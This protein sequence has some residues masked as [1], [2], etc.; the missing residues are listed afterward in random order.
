M[1][2]EEPEYMDNDFEERVW[3]AR[4]MIDLVLLSLNE[5]R[6]D[7]IPTALEEAFIK[8]QWLIDDYGV[9]RK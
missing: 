3:S 6:H 1:K 4:N 8:L 7:L 2:K 9:E 5:D